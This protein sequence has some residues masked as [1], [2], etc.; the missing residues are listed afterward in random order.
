MNS[1]S[2]ALSPVFNFTS[3][4]HPVLHFN[5]SHAPNTFTITDDTLQVEVSLDGGFTFTV[6]Y[7]VKP[8][9]ESFFGNHNSYKCHLY[10]V[11][12][13]QWRFEAVDLSAYAGNP[14]VMISF[15][16]KSQGGNNVYIG[17]VSV[18]EALNTSIQPVLFPTIYTHAIFPFRLQQ[19]VQLPE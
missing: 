16:F 2:R 19:W 18:T 12:A 4:L 8:V 1:E 13:G 7:P 15:R 10:S 11:N 14:Y 3:L 17:N 5:V 6:V 9:V